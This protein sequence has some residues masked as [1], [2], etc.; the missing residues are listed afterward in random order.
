MELMPW[1]ED[2]TS[3]D[4]GAMDEQKKR[5]ETEIRR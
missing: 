4:R 2:E 5:I 3:A 1:K